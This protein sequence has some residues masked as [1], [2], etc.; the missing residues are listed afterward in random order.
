MFSSELA[1]YC[2]LTC[3]ECGCSR[4]ISTVLQQLQANTF[5]QAAQTT[6]LKAQ[7]DQP[8][9]TATVLAPSDA[10]F[11]T[12]LKGDCCL[13]PPFNLMLFAAVLMLETGQVVSMA[14]ILPG[15]RL[16]P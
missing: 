7:F 8:G 10:A 13:M 9:F 3:G 16:K 2:Q 5:L 6:G 4:T 1:G 11:A 12:Y 15:N 14:G